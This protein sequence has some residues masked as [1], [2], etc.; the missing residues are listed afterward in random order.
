MRGRGWG[1]IIVGRWSSA[2]CIKLTGWWITS[3]IFVCFPLPSIYM[4]FSLSQTLS[5]PCYIIVQNASNPFQS[6]TAVVFV[7]FFVKS[8]FVCLQSLSL[9]L[10]FNRLYLCFSTT[11]CNWGP[12][13]NSW[14]P[15]ILKLK[16]IWSSDFETWDLLCKWKRADWGRS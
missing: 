7:V 2:A 15:M 13:A 3:P 11:Q 8:L 5:L 6:R 10:I 16:R 12:A 14:A 4:H 9:F 1:V